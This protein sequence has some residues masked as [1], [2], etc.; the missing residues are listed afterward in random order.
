MG[1]I[2]QNKDIKNLRK[3]K[4][5]EMFCTERFLDHFPDHSSYI[6]KTTRKYTMVFVYG[7][8]DNDT[9]MLKQ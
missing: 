7:I 5:C 2:Q 8:T 9:H 1:F 3:M 6:F 4:M